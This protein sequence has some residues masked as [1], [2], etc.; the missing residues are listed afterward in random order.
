M[1]YSWIY[2]KGDFPMDPDCKMHGSVS[3]NTHT[4]WFEYDAGDGGLMALDSLPKSGTYVFRCYYY[5]P[6]LHTWISY[7]DASVSLNWTV[8]RRNSSSSMINHGK[9]TKY[10][11]NT[12]SIPFPWFEFVWN[13]NNAEDSTKL[14][15]E[16]GRLY[17]L[18]DV[19]NGEKDLSYEELS[20]SWSE[21]VQQL[22]GS[23]K[24][25]LTLSTGGNDGQ[26]YADIWLA[27]NKLANFT[28]QKSCSIT[29]SKDYNKLLPD[30]ESGNLIAYCGVKI[31][32]YILPEKY[33]KGHDPM[34][35]T[36]SMTVTVPSAYQPSISAV[37]L[38]DMMYIVPSSWS[39]FVQHYSNVGISAI[40]A[41]ASYGSSI[42]QYSIDVGDA[43]SASGWVNYYFAAK[44]GTFSQY[45]TYTVTVSVKD[46]RGRTASKSA[47]IS[48]L[49]YDTPKFIS[50][51][52]DRCAKD[53]SADND[54]TYFLATLNTS[55][56]SCNGKNALKL[57]VWYRSTDTNTWPES[58]HVAV[59][60][61]SAG[62]ITKVY[63]GGTLDTE[64]SYDVHYRLTDQF[65]TIDYYDYVSTSI[66]LIHF[67]EGG[68]GAAF[69]QMATKD[70]TVD[71]AWA[72]YFRKGVTFLTSKGHEVTIQQIIDA[73]NL[74][75]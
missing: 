52:S 74:D 19:T 43:G 47:A 44:T 37:T 3:G 62:Q 35:N 67:K 10:H 49:Q 54:G 18:Y 11:S 5:D 55:Y 28:G 40:T 56:S 6:D 12:V 25:T 58:Q 4:V 26:Y 51:D 21:S 15:F 61:I 8:D 17:S 34:L 48:I 9:I 69:G 16:S 32:D 33:D 13:A 66:W 20:G 68:R 42:S 30:K 50:V 63:G 45:G 73:L 23:S 57:E 27:G 65:N 39:A 1:S 22:D 41:E 29:L 2:T 7:K 53:G 71:L 14:P 70:D 24:A 36:A 59:T 64:K 75:K 72:A 46:A 31:G 38:K 60:A